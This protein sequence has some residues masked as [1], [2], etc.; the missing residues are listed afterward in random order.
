MPFSFGA[1]SKDALASCQPVL[2]KIA[3]RAI[4]LSPYDFTILAG[5]DETLTFCTYPL[6]PSPQKY[7]AIAAAFKKA[8]D[9]EGVELRWSGDFR[10]FGDSSRIEI[11]APQASPQPSPQPSS[12]VARE[13]HS[14][15]EL[16]SLSDAEL[17]ARVVWGECRGKL[18]LEAR[19]IAHVVV[20]RASRPRWWGTSIKSCCLAPKQFS[21]LNDTDP[22]LAKILKG[23]FQDGSWTT[24]LQEASD[25]VAGK[26]PDPTAG[27]TSYHAASMSPYPSWAKTLTQTAKIG[28]HVFY[29]GE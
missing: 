29:R 11:D 12:P 9:E 18:D 22:N 8:A 16:A 15:A 27:A 19:A 10:F 13:L 20:N 23:N 4:V 26:S 14:R 25:A 3:N 21:C 5:G 1:H 2:Q 28:G 24:C 17:L 7:A 6:D